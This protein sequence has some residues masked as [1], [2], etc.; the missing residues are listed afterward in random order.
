MTLKEILDDVLMLSGADPETSYVDQGTAE[1]E[2]LV[3]LANRSAT[4]IAQWPWQVLRSRY[5]FTL[6]SD[7]EYELP[8]DFRSFIPDTMYT[9]GE[10]WGADFPTDT[11]M[12]AY[13]QASSG[14][15]G[16]R[17]QMRVLGGKLQVYEPESGREVSFEYVSK[18]PI[19]AADGT[20]KKERFTADTDTWRLDDDLLIKDLTWR[21]MKMVGLPD[22]Q[23]DALDFKNYQTIKRGDDKGAKTLIPG[24]GLTMEGPYYNLWRPVP[25]A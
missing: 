3:A 19:L 11:G 18:T 24:E 5:T 25:N 1:V 14:A 15:T 12:W 9:T 21:Y 8:S 22:W 23:V 6:T 20:T 13:L 7:T 16:A 10:V 2:R 4:A 17:F